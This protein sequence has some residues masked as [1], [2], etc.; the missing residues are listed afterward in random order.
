MGFYQDNILPWLTHLMMRP[1]RLMPHRQRKTT[2]APRR[3]LEM[4]S[5]SGLNQPFCGP[6]VGRIVGI[7]SS[8]MTLTNCYPCGTRA[9]HASTDSRGILVGRNV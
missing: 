7:E 6:G 5:G 3:V 9:V 4:S 1:S 2:G 8:P